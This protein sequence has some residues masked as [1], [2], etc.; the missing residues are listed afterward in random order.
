MSRHRVLVCS[1][2][3]LDEDLSESTTERFGKKDEEE[4]IRPVVNITD[5]TKNVVNVMH[6]QQIDR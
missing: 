3:L 1:E 6:L 2:E 5:G 4:K